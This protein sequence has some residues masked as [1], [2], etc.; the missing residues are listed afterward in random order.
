[1]RRTMVS[2]R[3]GSLAAARLQTVVQYM[4]DLNCKWANGID[5]RFEHGC[6]SAQEGESSGTNNS[7]QGQRYDVTGCSYY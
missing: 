5:F 3:L 7:G 1:M 2:I 6:V 4:Y